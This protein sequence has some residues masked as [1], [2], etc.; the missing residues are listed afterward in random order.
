L[1]DKFNQ[2]ISA[3]GRLIIG[4]TVGILFAGIISVISFTGVAFSGDSSSSSSDQDVKSL[5][6]STPG[7]R[8][9]AEARI[10]KAGT[11]AIPALINGLDDS[12]QIVRSRATWLLRQ[13]TYQ[14]KSLP[15]ELVA[16][17]VGRRVHNEKDRGTRLQMEKALRE[18][19]CP[20]SVRELKRL[21]T[22]DSESDIRLYAT[23]DVARASADPHK[24]IQF[25][26]QQTQDKNRAIQAAA[27]Y[28]LAQFGDS[29]GRDI[30]LQTISQSAV[31]VERVEAIQVL[32]AVGN[33]SDLSLLQGLR[34]SK[35]S[36]GT[37]KVTALN[38]MK[39][40]ELLR[41]PA[42]AQLEFLIKTLDE[43]EPAA[44]QWAYSKL[45]HFPDANTSDK[46]KKYLSE[47]GHIG[48]EEANNALSLR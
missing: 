3:N 40:I 21:A 14:F 36:N 33:A 17:E 11:G 8:Q 34:D 27:Y 31:T 22:E 38:A 29:S 6:D 30:A 35:S 5:G 25:F 37:I 4:R 12:N 32:G 39:N 18:Y 46:L 15:N 47:K 41:L 19:R 13:I 10:Q 16:R 24:E 43:R 9:T 7:V 2:A 45:W 42:G 20:T 28:E 23:H 44:R 1:R 26:K 48:Y